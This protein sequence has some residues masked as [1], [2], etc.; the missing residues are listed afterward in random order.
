MAF[1]DRVFDGALSPF[2]AHFAT[3]GKKLRPDEIAELEKILRVS[4]KKR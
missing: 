1:L 2:L 4:G 3:G